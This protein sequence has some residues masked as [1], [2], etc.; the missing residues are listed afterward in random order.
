MIEFYMG[1]AE[2]CAAM[3]RAVRSKVGTTIVKNDNILSFSWNGTPKNWDNTCEYREYLPVGTIITPEVLVEYPYEELTP[4]TNIYLRYKLVTKPEVLHAERNAI[5]KIAK[6][7]YSSSGASL[8]TT[9]S[10]C[11]ECAKSIYGAEIIEVYYKY[12][13]R[14]TAGLEFLEKAGIKIYK[15]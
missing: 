13:Y 14:I 7:N 1:I 9:H 3:S 15:V 6:S 10:P 5:D 12:D 4:A 8:F 2:N 11:E